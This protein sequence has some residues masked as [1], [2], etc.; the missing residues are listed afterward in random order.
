MGVG[1]LATCDGCHDSQW[2][3]RS[4]MTAEELSA[5]WRRAQRLEVLKRVEV[6]SGVWGYTVRSP[7]SGN[8]HVVV[9]SRGADEGPQEHY[10]K[11]ELRALAEELGRLG[12]EVVDFAPPGQEL[13]EKLGRVSVDGWLDAVVRVESSW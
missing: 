10:C 6:V 8:V 4:L 12:Y 5:R 3:S 2:R 9:V 13:V 7:R 1:L 11:H